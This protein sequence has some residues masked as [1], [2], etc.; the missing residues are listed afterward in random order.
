MHSFC[1]AAEMLEDYDPETSGPAIDYTFTILNLTRLVIN[2]WRI[3]YDVQH[4]RISFHTIDNTN[5]RYF[6]MSSFDFSCQTPVR[7]LDIQEDLSGNVAGDFID[8]TYE[9]NRTLIGKTFSFFVPD[10]EALDALAHY[11]ETT[12]CDGACAL[13]IEHK[14]IQYAKL[15]KDKKVVLKITGDEDFDMYSR[16]IWGRLHGGKSLLTGKRTA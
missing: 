4:R 10:E 5:I 15:L 8:Y 6:D 12:E 14:K 1:T 9:L 13:D 16:A 7:V 3:A 2:Q 11:P